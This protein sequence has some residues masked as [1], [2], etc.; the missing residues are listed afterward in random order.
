MIVLKCAALLGPSCMTA[1]AQDSTAADAALPPGAITLAPRQELRG[2]PVEERRPSD[3][4]IVK[5]RDHNR[6]RC[7][8]GAPLSRS[9]ADL[10]GVA[11]A[12]QRFGASL[13]PLFDRS[14]EELAAFERRAAGRS[15]RAQPDFAG[16]MVVESAAGADR[17]ALAAAL[18]E[19][20][21]VE[22]AY[23]S[24]T[25]VPPP[26][27]DQ[28]PA[29]DDHEALQSYMNADPGVNIVGARQ[30][31]DALGDG[32]TIANCEYGFF[33]LHEDLCNI[34]IE[35]GHAFDFT[36]D[37]N[38]FDHGTATMGQVVGLD[39]G[40]GCTGLAPDTDAM[41]FPERSVQGGA[42]RHAA[43]LNAIN[44]VDAG[45]IVMLE[46]QTFV[47]GDV[48]DG[49]YGP[50]ELD[51]IIWS[52]VRAGTDDDVIIVAAAGNGNQNLDSSN[53]DFYRGF[54]DSGAILVGAGTADTNHDKLGFSTFGS[55][56]NVQAWG[57]DVVTLG[58]GDLDNLN[59]DKYQTYTDTFGGTSSATPIV[60]S[61]AIAIQSLAIDIAGRRLGPEEMRELLRLTGIPQG[62]G[63]P[64]GPIPNAG[65]AGAA[66]DKIQ[67]RWVDFYYP[68]P[69]ELGTI[70]RPYNS[71]QEAIAALLPTARVVP[72]KA[73]ATPNGMVLT[74]DE[75]FTICAIGGVVVIGDAE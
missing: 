3:L 24:P 15:G 42:R 75:P 30:L 46:M 6:I 50:A 63:G 25:N 29:T 32:I 67:G 2:V 70:N 12:L 58:Y 20:A 51:P 14:E 16:M 74:D 26:C 31:G 21:L 62:S 7:D 28:A 22:F 68:G 17:V 23:F 69:S 44:A 73:S 45:D 37:P 53:Y 40:Y 8:A 65:S 54:G 61:C 38:T 72:I 48:D 43:V 39:N 1:V 18:N 36:L 55:R 27:V 47:Y 56:V 49:L 34:D 5:F 33:Q 9:G 13:R 35:D 64:I 71:V 19:S 60:A 59:N 52:I 10:T 66:L 41:F 11:A 57:E 4:L